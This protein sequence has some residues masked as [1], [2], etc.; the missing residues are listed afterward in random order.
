M[1]L[2]VSQYALANNWMTVNSEIE[3]TRKETSVLEFCWTDWIK[4]RKTSIRTVSSS[5]ESTT[6]NVWST[7]KKRYHL[8]KPVRWKQVEK[9]NYTKHTNYK[10]KYTDA[11]LHTASG[12]WRITPVMPRSLSSLY[13]PASCTRR[14][15]CPHHFE[16]NLLEYS[17]FRLPKSE[18]WRCAMPQGSAGDAQAGKTGTME[19]CCR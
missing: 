16:I 1:T 7:N 19:R 8:N 4:P 3:R 10:C 5:A 12:P 11:I 9:E 13:F 2:S 14:S 6:V 17:Y 18:S 15:Y